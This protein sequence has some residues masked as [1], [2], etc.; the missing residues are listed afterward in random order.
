LPHIHLW[1]LS[2]PSFLASPVNPRRCTGWN[3]RRSS[4]TTVPYP[5]GSLPCNR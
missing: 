2:M 3:V 5:A 1:P 4:P